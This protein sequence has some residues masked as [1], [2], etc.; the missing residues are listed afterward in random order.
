VYTAEL[1]TAAPE[2]Q[3][4]EHAAVRWVGPHELAEV[5]WVDADRAVLTDLA[6]LLRSGV[7][8]VEGS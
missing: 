7:A 5:D 4:L 2:P 3:A 1:D 8:A 6:A